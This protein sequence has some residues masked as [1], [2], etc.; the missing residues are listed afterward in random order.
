MRPKSVAIIGT[1]GIPNRYGGFEQFAEYL[2]VALAAKGHDV[3]VYN[4]SHHEYQSCSYS[5]VTITHKW[6]PEAYLGAAAHIIYDYVCL[7][8]AIRQNVD[9]VIELGYQSSALSMLLLH[10][11]GVRII[12]NM[13]GLEWKRDKWSWLVK[14]FTKWAEKTAV[15]KSDQLISDNIGIQEYIKEEYGRQSTMIPYGAEIPSIIDETLIDKY[16]VS[17]RSY[18]LAIARLEPENN[19]EMVLDGYVASSQS[20]PF[21]VVG[22]AS[23]KYGAMLRKKYSRANIQFAGGV[24]DKS[25]LDSL[26]FYTNAYFHGHSVGGTNPSLL[27]AM[28]S[29]S[30]I[31]AHSNVF[32][33]SVLGSDAHY[34]SSKSDVH[35]VILSL[36]D[37]GEAAA[38]EEG[39]KENNLRKIEE[40]FSWERVISQYEDLIRGVE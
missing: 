23:T 7:R 40:V 26:R 3:T 4:P 20:I 37:S 24:Y 30:L 9:V 29:R 28:A 12:T 5:G 33:R 18:F 2:S 11:G 35:Q 15:L 21:L 38:I 34:F 13:D 32:N 36:E 17:A 22:N 1:R 25:I 27:E 31:V 16:K 39:F 14:R 8:D 10:V 19:I 6:C